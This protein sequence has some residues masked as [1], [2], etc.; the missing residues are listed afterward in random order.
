VLCHLVLLLTS[1]HHVLA[2]DGDTSAVAAEVTPSPME[3]AMEGLE[4]GAWNT[5][6]R[7]CLFT[8]TWVAIV[9]A[10]SQPLTRNV[11]IVTCSFALSPQK[12]CGRCAKRLDSVVFLFRLFPT[13]A[14]TFSLFFY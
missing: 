2:A 11:R 14:T 6:S 7:L 13:I 10:F 8:Y 3:H 5:I 12:Y 4:S 9:T 1:V